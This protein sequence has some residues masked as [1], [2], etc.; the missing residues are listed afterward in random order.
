VW[1]APT[2]RTTSIPK[3]F[4]RAP[5]AVGTPPRLEAR[6]DRCSAAAKTSRVPELKHSAILSAWKWIARRN[7]KPELQPQITKPPPTASVGPSHLTKNTYVTQKRLTRLEHRR[8]GTEPPSASRRGLRSRQFLDAQSTFNFASTP[9]ADH[10]V[11]RAAVEPGAAWSGCTVRCVAVRPIAPSWR[12]E[13]RKGIAARP[14]CT[15]WCQGQE[16]LGQ[17]LSCRT[18]ARVPCFRGWSG[19]LTG[20]QHGM[21]RTFPTLYVWPDSPVRRQRSRN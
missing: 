15:Q 12:M 17:L 1:I 14:S 13:R 20:L 16:V 9:A 10:R 5:P 21:T 3:V 2:D 4:A 19:C 11:A 8:T 18:P 6:F 7:K